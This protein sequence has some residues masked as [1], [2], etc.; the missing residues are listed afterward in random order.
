VFRSRVQTQK[1]WISNEQKRL[2]FVNAR[3]HVRSFG[4]PLGNVSKS[5]FLT[6]K[7]VNILKWR[8]TANLGVLPSKKVPPNYLGI[9]LLPNFSCTNKERYFLFEN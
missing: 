7:V 8:E 6:Q 5:L 2:D 1:A 4:I 3:D 9:Q